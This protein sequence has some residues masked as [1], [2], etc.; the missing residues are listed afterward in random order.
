MVKKLVC[1]CGLIPM[2]ALTTLDER[3]QKW[4]VEQ[5]KQF[6]FFYVAADDAQKTEYVKFIENGIGA[7]ESFFGAS[8]KNRFD[9][10]VHPNR[11]SLDSTWQHD[12]KIPDFKSECWMVASGVATKI[13]M[14]S[15]KRW[16]TEACEHKYAD[17]QKTQQLII[18]ELVHVFHGQQN[19]SPDFSDVTDIDW[20]VEGLATYVS[21]QCTTERLAEVK[22]TIAENRIPQSLNQF[23]SGK[24]KYGL[25]GSVVMFIDKKYGRPK[26]IELLK[27]NTF[28]DVLTTL[29]TDEATLLKEWEEYLILDNR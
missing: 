13:D 17:T 21:G 26:L 5:L 14:I 3:Q 7:V 2:L 11:K 19:V 22:K 15:P 4:Q 12:W 27:F 24:L 25:S 29:A 9:V 1:F 10:Y 16:D 8:Y 23:W 6:T 28:T 18:H 20:F